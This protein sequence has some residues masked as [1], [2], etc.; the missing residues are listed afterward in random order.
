MNKRGQSTV[1]YAVIVAVAIAALLGMQF[2]M[3]RGVQGKLRES[4]DQIAE[5]YAPGKTASTF[6]VT[7]SGTR[8]ETLDTDGKSV[9][10]VTA[11]EA[12]TRTGSETVDTSG[13]TKLF[14]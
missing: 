12:Q 1:E 13:E 14:P 6:T 4:T 8:N 3:K 10:T 7:S 11:D 5:Q 2:Y 9:S